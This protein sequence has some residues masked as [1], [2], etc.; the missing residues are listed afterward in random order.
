M[1]SDLGDSIDFQFTKS[2]KDVF[3]TVTDAKFHEGIRVIPKKHQVTRSASDYRIRTQTRPQ[4]SNL[5]NF[6][7]DKF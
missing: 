2:L 1:E 4:S 7:R 6:I 3:D 5:N